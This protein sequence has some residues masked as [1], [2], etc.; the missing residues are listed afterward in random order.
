MLFYQAC[1]VNNLTIRFPYSF[2]QNQELEN[3]AVHSKYM[4]KYIKVKSHAPFKVDWQIKSSD[5][6]LTSL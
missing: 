4:E 3:D 1:E 2:T 5:A 6:F